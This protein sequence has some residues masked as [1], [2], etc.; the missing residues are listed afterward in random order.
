MATWDCV[1]LDSYPQ[2]E[3]AENDALRNASWKDNDATVGG[4]R[5]RRISK[6]DVSNT[7][8][9]GDFSGYRHFRY[10][11]IVASASHGLTNAR[12]EAVNNKII[13]RMAYSFRN[14]ANLFSMV[15]RK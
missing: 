12:M 5:Y 11:P 3:V 6:A 15:M 8:N 2:T 10:E 4:V 7:Y 13:V 14:V 1:W 9:V